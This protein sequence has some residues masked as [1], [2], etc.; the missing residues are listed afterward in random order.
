MTEWKLFD[1]EPPE[2]EQYLAERCRMGLR[3][4]PGFMQ[5]ARMVVDLVKLSIIVGGYT[6]VTDLGCGDGELL[7]MMPPENVA[8]SWGYELGKSDV[9]YGIRRGL[10]VRQANIVTGSCRLEYGEIVVI[11]EVLEHLAD[12]R[13]LL[14]SLPDLR[15]VI[16]SSPSL[17]TAEWHN[18]SHAWAW[19]L[20]G[21]RDLFKDCGYNVL[22]QNDSDGGINSFDGAVGE[23][24]FQVIVA[25]R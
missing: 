14:K 8:K 16:A 17:E 20:D 7:T 11:S 10:D 5:R 22:Y 19:D 4:Q 15:L 1:K 18:E 25:M 23:Q 24:R 2:T 13:S 21:Y 9:Q 12:P 6:S 3:M